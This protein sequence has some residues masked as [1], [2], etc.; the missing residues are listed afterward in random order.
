MIEMAAERVQ[1]MSPLVIH[2]D[3][4]IKSQE[5]ITRKMT[6]IEKSRKI[7]AEQL[8]RGGMKMLELSR[9]KKTRKRPQQYSVTLIATISQKKIVSH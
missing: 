7:N 4:S 3:N 9:M 1:R 2:R 5:A 8:G 6:V